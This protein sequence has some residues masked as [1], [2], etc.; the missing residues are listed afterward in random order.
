MMQAAVIAFSMLGQL[1]PGSCPTMTAQWPDGPLCR[2]ANFMPANRAVDCVLVD[3]VSV[4]DP[5]VDFQVFAAEVEGGFNIALP[6]DIDPG[7]YFLTAHLL[8][9]GKCETVYMGP[10]LFDV[11]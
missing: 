4:A 2:C 6:A 7:E 10:K 11:E 8:P 3:V 9:F 5:S 1:G